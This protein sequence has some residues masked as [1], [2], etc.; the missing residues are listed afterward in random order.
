VRV[1]SDIFSLDSRSDTKPESFHE[2]KDRIQRRAQL[3]VEGT[4]ERARE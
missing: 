3:I 4:N 2:S 1:Y